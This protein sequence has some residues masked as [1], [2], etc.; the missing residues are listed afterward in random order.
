MSL[1]TLNVAALW[2][3]LRD[4]LDPEVPVL[5]VVDLGIVRDVRVSG[6]QVDVDITPTYSGCPAMQVIE[7]DIVAALE[8][9]GVPR[10]RVHTVYQPAW[11]TDWISA[12]ARERLRAYGI[13]PPSR[14]APNESEFVTLHR[15]TVTVACPR[16]GSR[17]T[18]LQSEF[19]ATACK[20]MWVCRACKEPFEEFK[21][22]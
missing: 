11:S 17:D 8:A 13:A 15:R 2:D 16:C 4:V 21:P 14:S 3:A 19:G 7:H 1:T 9:A 18:V 12:D 5:S 6:D 10:V 22:F 20:A